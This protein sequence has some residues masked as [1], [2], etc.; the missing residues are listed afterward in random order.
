[1]PLFFTKW[2]AE[3]TKIPAKPK[4]GSRMS[5]TNNRRAPRQR[6]FLQGRIYYNNRRSS[7]DCTVRDI[8]ETGARLTFPTAVAIPEEIELHIPQRKECYHAKVRWQRGREVGVQIGNADSTT[9]ESPSIAPAAGVSVEERL[10]RLEHEVAI[11]RRRLEE[12]QRQ[13]GSGI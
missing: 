12:T 1:L 8:N 4:G 3:E 2:K 11:L 6:S 13:G 5:E 7:A 10:R 9:V